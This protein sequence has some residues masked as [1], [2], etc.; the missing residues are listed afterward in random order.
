MKENVLLE[1]TLIDKGIEVRLSEEAY[2]NVYLIGLLELIKNDL[3]NR[4]VSEMD[5]ALSNKSN[6]KKVKYDA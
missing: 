3:L 1:L 6:L 5:K 2:G 4:D